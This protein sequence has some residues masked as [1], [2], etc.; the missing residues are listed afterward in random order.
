MKQY[1]Q[2][3]QYYVEYQQQ[4]QQQQYY[5]N[6]ASNQAVPVTTETSVNATTADNVNAAAA[7]KEVSVGVE[8]LEEEKPAS[9]IPSPT[10]PS[11]ITTSVPT[12][13]V[14]SWSEQ[15]AIAIKATLKLGRK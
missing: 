2:Q 10:T 4:Q 13:K 3:Q 9:P 11:K 7:P 15:A 8:K 6:Q 12:S 14:L 1:Y 5:Q